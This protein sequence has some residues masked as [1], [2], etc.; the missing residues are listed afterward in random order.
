VTDTRERLDRPMARREVLKIAGFAGFAAGMAPILAACGAAASPTVSAAA[1]AATGGVFAGGKSKR[2]VVWV[3]ALQDP[4]L[5]QIIFGTYSFAKLRGW[6]FSVTGPQQFD[7]QKEVS[8]LETALAQKPDALVFLRTDTTSFE[9]VIT[10]AK[11]QGTAVS[12][13]N[14]EQQD[15]AAKG[16]AIV[17]TDLRGGGYQCGNTLAKYAQQ[18][19]NR[20]DGIIICSNFDP[21]APFQVQRVGGFKDGVTAYNT[22]N[23]TSYTVTVEKV[24]DDPSQALPAM[25]AIYQ[26]DGA[27]IVGMGW[28]GFGWVN[29]AQ[30][31]KQSNRVGKIA[32]GGLDVVNAGMP[33]ISDGSAQ[34]TIDEDA[35]AQGFMAGSN[36]DIFMEAH[37]P[38]TT[39]RIALNL[40]DK[41]NVD[42]I[43]KNFAALQ[44]A[45][46]AA[47]QANWQ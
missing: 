47:A 44:A 19:T 37:Y 14:Q 45:A 6:E 28:T 8:A 30:W 22:A 34:F 26:R 42:Q 32:N 35:Y 1:G 10:R 16:L 41:T 18:M 5:E 21:S 2:R 11:A 9:D 4:V 40:V 25:D 23:G 39:M 43:V 31:L 36:L 13:V 24:S 3:Q 20:K 46:T 27:N 7:T 38:Q 33:S 12:V 29:C 15:E 17:A